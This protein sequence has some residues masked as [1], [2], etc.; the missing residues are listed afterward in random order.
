MIRWEVGAKLTTIFFDSQ[1]D[2][3]FIGQATSNYFIG[4]GPTVALYLVRELP[5]TGPA[6]YGRIEGTVGCSAA[7][8]SVTRNASATRPPRTASATSSRAA[9]RACRC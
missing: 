8:G 9:R 7:S 1:V 4:A 5:S 3:A 2:G 6:L